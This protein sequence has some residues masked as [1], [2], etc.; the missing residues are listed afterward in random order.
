MVDHEEIFNLSY[1]RV[2]GNRVGG[3]SFFDAFQDA[4]I[5]SSDE[6]AQKMKG[7]DL[8][9]FRAA[10]GLAIVH[11]AAYYGKGKPDTILQGIAQRQNR[12]GRNIEPHLYDYFL[13][14]LLETVE[15]FDPEYTDEERSAWEIV[16][17]PG[18]EYLKRM[19]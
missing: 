3:T 10:L 18:L 6:V 5:R 9:R 12:S 14:A 8:D 19:Y 16:L 15:L 4:L 7:G 17:R 1:W 13:A 2:T 11:L